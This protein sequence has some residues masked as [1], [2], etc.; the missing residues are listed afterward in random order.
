MIVVQ[1]WLTVLPLRMQWTALAALR[2]TDT[3][4]L[5]LSRIVVRWLRG[6]ILVPG[7]P[8]NVTQFMALIDELPILD[9]SG[10]LEK[11]LEHSPVHFFCHLMES[12]EVIAYEHPDKIQRDKGFEFYTKMVKILELVFETHAEMRYRLRDKKWPNDAHPTNAVEAFA[13]MGVKA[14][15]QNGQDGKFLGYEV[16][17]NS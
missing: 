16:S 11:E 10:P 15:H 3:P 7:N 9:E 8:E 1:T 13:L 12:I 4:F 17:Y 6:L 14:V 5:P 2:C